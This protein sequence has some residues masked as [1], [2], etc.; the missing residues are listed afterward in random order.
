LV[1]VDYLSPLKNQC[2]LTTHTEALSRASRGTGVVSGNRLLPTEPASMNVTVQA[3]RIRIAGVPVDVAEDTAV[4]DTAHAT[5]PRI[6]VIYRDASGDAQV[7]KGTPAAIEDPKNL[8]NWKSYTSPIPAESIPAGAILGV[9]YVP[10]AGATIPASNIWMFAAGTEDLATSVGNPGTN[11]RAASEKAVRDSINTCAPS[12][13]GVTNGNSHDHNGGDGAQINHVNLANKGSN[14]HATIDTH[15]ASTSNPHSTTAAQV[16]ADITTGTAHAATSKATPVD[17]DEVSLLDSAASYGLKKLTWAN[18]KATLLATWHAATS[19]STPVDA[20]ELEILDSAASFG[21]KRLTWS[22]LKATLKTYLD[23]LYAPI[24]KGVTNGD[25]HDHSGGDGAQ[26]H[27]GGLAGLS[28]DDHPQYVRH[29]LATAANDFLVA[30]GSGAFVKKT[31]AEVKSI[32]GLGSAAYTES[33]AYAPTAKGVT[34]G[35]SHD[36]NGGDGAQVH[37]GGLAGLSDDDHPQYVRHALATAANDFLVA[38]GSGAFV[39]KTLAEVKSILGLGSAAYTESTAY[40][41]TAKGVTNGDSHDHNGGDGAQIDHTNLANKG[42]NTHATIDTHLASTSNPHST[43]Y[44]QV[45]AAPAAQ[46]VTNG[47]S[48]DHSGGDGAQISYSSLSG[49]PLRGVDFAFGDGSDVLTAQACS[50][51]IPSASTIIKSYIRSLDTDGALK[52]GSIT[53]TIYVHD[54]NAAIGSAVDSFTLSSASSRAETGLSISVAAGKYITCILSGISTVEQI[55][56]SLEMEA[57]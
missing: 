8:A 40:A 16:G 12:A 47:N 54:Y 18:L 43:T 7:A 30:S 34:N 20:D 51:R 32:L 13:Q 57:A 3:G 19:K 36:H 6:D 29:A 41:P 44:G 27:H 26:V 52:V 15:L 5:Y 23:T 10:A 25:S 22:N 28:D 11:A 42:S 46:G 49:L 38:S 33:T 50:V 35:D 9:V 37:H 17:T 21:Q 24:A 45:G 53:C 14:T 1:D 56:L 55:V 4:I 48:H 2:I 39:K 31:L